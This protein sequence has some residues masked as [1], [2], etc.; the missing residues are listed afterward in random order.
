[1]F[2]FYTICN[3]NE[4]FFHSV[5]YCLLIKIEQIFDSLG[6]DFSF[7]NRLHSR[8][9]VLNIISFSEKRLHG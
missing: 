8:R 3:S 6:G 9:D 7:H 4:F 5:F 1:M 2:I